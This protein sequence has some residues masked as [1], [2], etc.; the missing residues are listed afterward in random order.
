M[1]KTDINCL[2]GHWPFRKIRKNSFDDLKKAHAEN[3][4]SSGYVSSIDSIFYNDPFEG[5]EEL[6]E[7]IKGS[8]Y[9]HVLTV[10]PALPEYTGDIEKGAKLFDIKGV[11]IYPGYHGYGLDCQSIDRLCAILRDLRLPLFLTLRMED[12]RLDHIVR[13]AAIQT[14]D[15]AKFIKKYKENSII[16]LNIRFPELMALKDAINSNK[17][18]FFD[19]CGLKDPLFP[20]E[21]LLEIFDAEKIL[22]G[23]LYPLYCMKSSTLIV[24]KADIQ[25]PVKEKIFYGN[26]L[27]L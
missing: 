19:T 17:N 8:G 20:V 16:L 25:E 12:E 1:L 11:R 24:E 23:S 26:S 3:G 22:Y 4:I 10:N 5:D 2:I 15:L 14:D 13:P 7:I 6:H 9:H 21:R 18:V 27:Q